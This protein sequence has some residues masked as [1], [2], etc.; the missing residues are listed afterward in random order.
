MMKKEFDCNDCVLANSCDDKLYVDECLSKM[1]TRED[2]IYNPGN[3]GY[4]MKCYNYHTK[5]NLY[6]GLTISGRNELF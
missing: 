3:F 1:E 4:S 6:L 2:N 5:D